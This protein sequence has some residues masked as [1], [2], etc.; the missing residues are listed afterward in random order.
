MSTSREHPLGTKLGRYRPSDT[1]LAL[2]VV[3]QAEQPQRERSD[4]WRLREF[5]DDHDRASI[6]APGDDPLSG[7]PVPAP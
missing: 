5:R 3:E 7:R 4:R 2:R 1:L 6:R